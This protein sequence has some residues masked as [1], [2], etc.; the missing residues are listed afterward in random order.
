MTPL[1][2]AHFS[3]DVVLRDGATARVREIVASD[4][5]ELDAFFHALSQDSLYSRFFTVPKT[6]GAEIE[7][8]IRADGRDALAI[9]A[10]FGGR[11]CGVASWTRDPD[12]PRRAEAAFVV[13]DRFQ[14][15]GLGTRMLEILAESARPSVIETFDAYVLAA[16]DSMMRVFL[17]SGFAVESRLESGVIHVVFPLAATPQL[18]QHALE[19]SEVAAAASLRPVL[20]PAS[21]V[22]VG[23]NRT[24]GKIGA[25]V[26]HNL[27]AGGFTG[28]L[29][30]VHPSERSIDGV[31]ACASVRDV[32]GDIDLA[33]IC[34]PARDVLHV[35]DDCIEKGVKALCVISAGFAESG[36]DGRAREDAILARVR[37]AGIR[38]IGPNCLGVLNTD[39]SIQLNA[40]FAGTP[41]VRGRVAMSTQSG[42][43]GLAILDYARGLNIGFSTFVSVGN[44]ADVSS[45]DLLQYWSTDPDTD[46]VLLYLESF[47]NPRKFAQIAR[48]VS[49]RKAIV[50]VKAGRSSSG[51]RAAASHTGALASGDAVVDALFQQAGVI[52]TTTIE[53]LF[54]VT[55]LLAHQ[56][57][58]RGR[59]VAIV[60]NAGGP[61]I[62][63]ADACEAHG[64]RL[65]ALSDTTVGELRSFLPAAASVSNPVDLLASAS[66]GH[67]ERALAA[68]LNDPG[69]DSVLVIF[70]P[71][72]VTDAND[73]AE[74][75]R[76]AR[77]RRPDKT[78]AAIFMSTAG[79]P[80]ALGAIP[81]FRFPEAAATA[82]AH[83]VR[84]FEWLGEPEG[85]A[86]HLGEGAAAAARAIVDGALAR[87]GGWLTAAEARSLFEAVDIR[88]AVAEPA[89]TVDDA[90]RVAARIG[91]PVALKAIG[92][93]IVHKTD[94]GG[95]ALNIRTGEELR[96]AWQ[97]L[98]RRLGARM[99]GALVQEM[100]EDGVEM[101][102][103]AADDSIF[104]PVVT[105]AMG[106]ILTELLG[107]AAFRL[108][109]LRDVDARAMVDG[110]KGARLLRGYRGHPAVDEPAL[111][112]SLMRLSM[113]VEA[114]PEIRELDVNP[115]M[116]RPKGAVAVDVRVRVE[117]LRAKPPTRRIVY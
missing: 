8:L 38:L 90:R 110:L 100:V 84:R 32:S 55:S 31:A 37:S 61:G 64:L 108:H 26:L 57:L 34:V 76:R 67:Y 54:D 79:A 4:A 7:R 2:A 71:P 81:C 11:V 70:I 77:D 51:A 113:L 40:T 9:L 63:A 25:E 60:T 72:L 95:V 88:M 45:N 41:P 47:G 52:R 87:G 5:P 69:V 102:I 101:L 39:P 112:D 107:D 68:V 96:D 92:P 36:A 99:T 12:R 43:L 78:L 33:V 56:P 66:A 93:D 48:R 111:R 82:L 106:G 46:V 6:P 42:A 89:P 49:R 104:G 83:A 29:H 115:L 94:V 85:S 98:S 116:V 86:A 114:C 3:Y 19:R 10:E 17:D 35:V 103:G 117:P 44:K 24:R 97:T 109:P 58:P 59:S 91:Y 20:R 21:V 75:I 1:A 16:N 50:A 73:V 15:R 65:P 13:A 53:E 23:A 80:H 27:K 62:L 22:V 18:Q 28:R 105:C 74:A 14:G 30:A